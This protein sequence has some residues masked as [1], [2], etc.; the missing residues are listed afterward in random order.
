MYIAGKDYYNRFGFVYDPMFKSLFCDN[1]VMDVAKHLGKYHYID[2]PGVIVHLNPAYG[3]SE[4]DAM[5]LEQQ[6]IGYSVD[7]ETYKDIQKEGIDAY[8]KFFL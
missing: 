8:L 1:L 4:K 3:H 2:I 5:F 7:Y 6:E